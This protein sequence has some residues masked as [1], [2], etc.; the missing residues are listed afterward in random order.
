MRLQ[1][2]YSLNRD[3]H[4]Q[5]PASPNMVVP[6]STNR[7]HSN[8]HRSGGGDVLVL[9]LM[10]KIES[11]TELIVGQ[12]QLLCSGSGLVRRV[13]AKSGIKFSVHDI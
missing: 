3:V 9:E 4:E 11:Q 10:E 1:N 8:A 13:G 7:L 12:R 6:R 2:F 5:L